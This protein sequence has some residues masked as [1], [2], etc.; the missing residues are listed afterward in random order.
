[1]SR[2]SHLTPKQE[3]VLQFIREKIEGGM[4]PTIREIA[5]KLKFS[6]TGTVRDYLKVLQAKGFLRRQ[7]NKS[8]AIELLRDNPTRIPILSTI[9]AGSPNEAYEDILGYLEPGDFFYGRS[10]KDTFALRVKGDSMIEAG[11][12]EG[13]IAVIKKQPTAHNKD[14]IAA[15]MENNEVT[16]KIFRQKSSAYYLE[17]ANKNYQPIYRKFTVIGKLVTIVR[18]YI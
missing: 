11:I 6:S 10:L 7:H 15:L 4:P 13:D 2:H 5:H 16:L 3:K 14:I 18:R 8:R 12:M 1:M 9:F 17:P